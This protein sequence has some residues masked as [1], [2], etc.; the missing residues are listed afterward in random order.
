MGFKAGTHNGITDTSAKYCNS[1]CLMH[2]VIHTPHRQQLLKKV[3]PVQNCTVV[4]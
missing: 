1:K 4:L 2:R 3:N